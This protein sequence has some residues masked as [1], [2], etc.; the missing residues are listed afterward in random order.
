LKLS[1]VGASR[2][3][4][5]MSMVAS[6]RIAYFGKNIL[7]RYSYQAEISIKDTLY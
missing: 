3:A 5:Q 1:R 4:M 7:A 6:S 2:K